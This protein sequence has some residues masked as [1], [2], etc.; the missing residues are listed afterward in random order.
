MMV[1]GEGN[2][3]QKV[4]RGLQGEKLGVQGVQPLSTFSTGLLSVVI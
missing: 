2:G 4:G 1:P 3:W